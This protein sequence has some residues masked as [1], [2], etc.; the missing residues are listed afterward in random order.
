LQGGR[1]GW[2]LGNNLSCDGA[3]GEV[4]VGGIV[5]YIS[6][7]KVKGADSEVLEFGVTCKDS[8]DKA[9]ARR[10]SD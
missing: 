7:A 8:V 5:L 2:K 1:L 9:G 4:V 10:M 6:P 3:E